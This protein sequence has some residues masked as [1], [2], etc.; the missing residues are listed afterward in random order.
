M[1]MD[2]LGEERLMRM[3]FGYQNFCWGQQNRPVVPALVKLSLEDSDFKARMGYK[4]KP[5]FALFSKINK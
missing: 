2:V 3:N 5:C 1:Y 4:M